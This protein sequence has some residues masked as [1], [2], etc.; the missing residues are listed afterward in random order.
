MDEH[1]VAETTARC[2]A[3]VAALA[4]GLG[5][6]FDAAAADLRRLPADRPVTGALAAALVVVALRS[7]PSAGAHRARHLDHLLGLADRHPPAAPEWPRLRAVAP[8]FAVV[9]T[10]AGGA[11]FD[12]RSALAGDALL[13]RAAAAAAAAARDAA[14]SAVDIARSCLMGNDPAAAVQAL[15]AGRALVLFAATEFL[16][17]P[18]RLERIGRSGLATR[19]RLAANGSADKPGDIPTDLRADVLAALSAGP[20][21]DGGRPAGPLAPPD[22]PEI[23]AALAGLDA[24]ALVYLLPATTAA[25]GWAVMVPAAGPPSFMALPNLALDVDVDVEPLLATLSTRDP[26]APDV[27]ADTMTASLD[28][29]CDWAWRAAIGPLVERYLP[30]LPTPGHR[31]PRIVLVPQGN[32]ARV[33]WQAARRGDGTYAVQLAAFSQAA[34]ARMLCRSASATPVPVLPVGLVV[35]DPDTHGRAPELSAA[36]VEAYAVHQAFYPGARYVGRRA[37]GSPSRSGRGTAAEVREWLTTTRPAAGTML[38]LA[39]HG[40]IQPAEADTTSYLLLATDADGDRL[41]AEDLVIVLARAPER[42]IGLVV[43]AACR[44]GVSGR[45]YDEAFSLGTAFLVAGVRSVL[46]TQW[47]VPDRDTSV[48][49]YLFHHFLMAERRPV[50]DALRR[51]QL[52]MLDPD[53]RPPAGMPRPLVRQLSEADPARVVAWAGVVH[54]GQ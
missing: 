46:S 40:M 42:A 6:D 19:W 47:R 50:W 16:D 45:G 12:T 3:T 41:S 26:A 7:E 34:S 54:G 30:E 20:G 48:L 15:D 22:L 8:T 25:T 32:L 33:P 53:R 52:W 44:A 51:A 29:L 31:P 38:H 27:G 9:R 24:D 23:R 37:D 10:G 35:G 21:A 18:A 14:G 49:M 36:R 11:S 39:C 4:T 5:G 28:I 43:L 1:T 2:A 17:V 13:Q